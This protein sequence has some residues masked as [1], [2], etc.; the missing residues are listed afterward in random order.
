M[1]MTV[2]P[3]DPAAVESSITTVVVHG[4]LTADPPAAVECG[5]H[6]TTGVVTRTTVEDRPIRTTTKVGAH[7]AGVWAAA[8]GDGGRSTPATLTGGGDRAAATISAAGSY[9]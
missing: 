6:L 4:L 1:A 8:R 3:A 2:G 7:I 9:A 5:T